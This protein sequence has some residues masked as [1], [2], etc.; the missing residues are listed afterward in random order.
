M[1]EEHIIHKELK[2]ITDQEIDESKGIP[3]EDVMKMLENSI[4]NIKWYERLYYYP[5][6]RIID[7]YRWLVD[8]WDIHTRGYKSSEVFDLGSAVVRY[9]LPK[10]KIFR[11]N[12]CSHPPDYT[13][14]EWK[15][16][17]NR[18]IGSFEW[19]ESIVEMEGE[20]WDRYKKLSVEEQQIEYSKY[21]ENMVL[22]AKH[23]MT[24]W[25]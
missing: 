19:Y 17:L 7:F 12:M 1:R 24:L 21:E 15:D 3:H 11:D 5:K 23:L 25:D 8:I 20:H 14:E 4:N 16:I 10:M 9:T 2:G 18:I 6:H 22:F 13:V